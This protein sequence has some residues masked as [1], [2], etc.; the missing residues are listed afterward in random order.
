M[1]KDELKAFVC[2]RQEIQD[3]SRRIVQ[4]E[5][6]LQGGVSRIDGLPWAPGVT[7]KIGDCVPELL[8]LREMTAKQLKTALIALGRI[9]R[10]IN[11]V[12]DP[13]LRRIF[14]LRHI[15]NLS[16]QQ[17]SNR[18]GSVTADT[19]RIKHNRYLDKQDGKGAAARFRR[20]GAH[21]ENAQP[22]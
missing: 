3:L 9:Q 10:F 15:H 16:W 22:G 13:L 4:I 12:E 1:I 18:I 17:V 5:T 14:T 6:A 11:A 2:L 19:C 20:S 21:M 7:D 8:A